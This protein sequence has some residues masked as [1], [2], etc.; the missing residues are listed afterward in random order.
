MT[1]FN[2]DECLSSLQETLTDDLNC[3]FID[4][5]GEEF[6]QPYEV[7][8][9]C[10]K[11]LE[12]N[13]TK[14]FTDNPFALVTKDYVEQTYG[15]VPVCFKSPAELPQDHPIMKLRKLS[16]ADKVTQI[17]PIISTNKDEITELIRYYK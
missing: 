9:I 16:T 17:K 13:L 5:R 2:L 8:F 7:S 12:R 1:E 3:F 15:M 6:W 4:V 14:T 11:L 10:M